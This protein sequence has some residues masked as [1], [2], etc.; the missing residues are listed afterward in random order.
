M[1][2][3]R[4]LTR[5]GGSTGPAVVPGILEESW[6]YNAITHQ[7]F[8]MPPKRKLPRNIINDFRKWI[9]MGAPDP[10]QTDVAEIKSS[11][12]KVDVERAR[13][14]FWAY[15]KPTKPQPPAIDDAA[16]P[17]TDIDR[18][19]L[20]KLEQ[21]E[22]QPASDA[23]AYK[24]LRR[25]CFD[26]IGLPPTPEQVDDFTKQ[27]KT[28]PDQAIEF[29]VDRLLKKK[30]FGERW[31]RHWLDLVR[32]AEST[33]H[34][35]NYTYP[36]AWRYRD[37]VIDSFNADKPFDRFVQEQIAGDLLPVK[38]DEQWAENL[39]AT[40][41]LAIGPKNVN[42]RNRAQFEAD[43][44][45]EQI[46]ATTR[47][48]LGQSVACARRHDHKFDAIPQTDYYALAGVFRNA[49][50][51]SATRRRSS[52]SSAACKLDAAVA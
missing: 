35:Y 47:V 5:I 21:A 9:E 43:L 7:D 50:R 19:V 44:I 15:R 32:Y 33:G 4:E 51:T 46:D 27:W 28:D 11:I 30:Q 37:Y 10:R 52:A 20:A 2:D 8:D 14:S 23:E 24:V 17:R 34:E 41:F 48:F 6:L 38:S 16:W 45:D 42:E 12:S 40:T 13:E 26:L 3:A 31:G 18:F 25:L 22:L 39:I 1:M 49:T 36:H 29:V